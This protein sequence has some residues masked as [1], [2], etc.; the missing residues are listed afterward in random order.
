MKVAM[1]RLVRLPL[2][3]LTS[4]LLNLYFNVLLRQQSLENTLG[5]TALTAITV[6]SIGN[7]GLGIIALEVDPW[8]HSDT[9]ILRLR[10]T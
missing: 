8:R 3:Q 1:Y 4:S 9:V 5:W 7:A 6:R 2:S 10:G